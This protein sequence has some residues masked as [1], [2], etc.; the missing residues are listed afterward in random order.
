VLGAVIVVNEL[1]HFCFLLFG[2][3]PVCSMSF[4]LRLLLRCVIRIDTGKRVN[5]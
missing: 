4:Y 2:L 3:L 5:F 1:L